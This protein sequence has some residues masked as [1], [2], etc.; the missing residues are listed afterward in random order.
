M[1]YDIRKVANA[2]LYFLDKD[3][4]YLGKTKL[5]K[6]LYFADKYHLNKYGRPIFNDKYIK[7]QHGPVP[8]LTLNII[9]S[10]NQLD[11]EDLEE[12]TEKLREFVEIK[13]TKDNQ[14]KKTIF[15]KKRQL[16]IDIFSKSELECMNKSIEAF[17]EWTAE[18][19]S[20]F[21]HDLEEYKKTEMNDIISY[22]DMSPK[23]REYISFTE[24]NNREFQ[25]L[26]A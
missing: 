13:E 3:V 7:L 19:I 8:S 16:N 12:Y 1:G 15:E 22:E 5:M 26:F 11:N 18:K 2:I 25:Q 24:K 6:L 10:F 21:S 23:N 14:Y 20:E 9:N 4:K 17:K